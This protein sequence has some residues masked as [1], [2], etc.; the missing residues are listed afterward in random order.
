MNLSK[1]DPNRIAE[2]QG[3]DFRD[4][5]QSTLDADFADKNTRGKVLPD[6]I[7]QYYTRAA[8]S[9]YY[10]GHFPNN[11]PLF[12]LPIKNLVKAGDADETPEDE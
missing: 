7:A 1:L 4:V 5:N 6:T 9:K 8:S 11:F 12:L 10:N 3:N 2:S